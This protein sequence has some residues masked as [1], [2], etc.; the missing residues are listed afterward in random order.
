MPCARRVKMRQKE[1]LQ[2]VS[3]TACC[4]FPLACAGAGAARGGLVGIQAD[5]AGKRLPARAAQQR[6]PCHT[7]QH[8]FCPARTPQSTKQQQSPRTHTTTALPTA[9]QQVLVKQE[10][11]EVKNNVTKRIEF[12]KADIKRLDGIVKKYEAQ[13]EGV[14]GNISALQ[15]GQAQAAS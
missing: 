7:Q 15:K 1:Q 8:F 12:I 9:A 2:S 13:L 4:F 6:H 3:P 11:M 5:W 14:K 10:L